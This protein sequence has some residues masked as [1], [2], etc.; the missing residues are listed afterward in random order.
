MDCRMRNEGLG[1]RVVDSGSWVEDRR[2]GFR[3]AGVGSGL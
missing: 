1:F 3:V 2:C